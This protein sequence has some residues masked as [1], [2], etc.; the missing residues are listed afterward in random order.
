MLLIIHVVFLI[1]YYLVD[2]LIIYL[3]IY[4]VETVFLDIS[5]FDPSH[6]TVMVSTQCDPSWSLSFLLPYSNKY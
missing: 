3:N 6:A 5:E 2:I 1:I 4:Y